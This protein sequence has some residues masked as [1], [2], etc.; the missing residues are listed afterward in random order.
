MNVLILMVM[1][2]KKRKKSYRFSQSQQV[3]KLAR[4]SAV[5]VFNYPGHY[6]SDEEDL[7]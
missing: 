2:K 6:L 3:T 1:L 4:E 5:H 7:C